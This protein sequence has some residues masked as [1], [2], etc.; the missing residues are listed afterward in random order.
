VCAGGAENIVAPVP[1]AA[2]EPTGVGT[3]YD[4]AVLTGENS[5]ACCSGGVGYKHQK[6]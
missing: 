5:D 6:M 2:F 3:V 4:T 1:A